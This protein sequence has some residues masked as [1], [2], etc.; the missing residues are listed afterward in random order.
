MRESDKT[1]TQKRKLIDELNS[2]SPAPL[3]ENLQRINSDVKQLQKKLINIYPRFGAPY[4]VALDKFAKAL[5]TTVPE[6]YEKW[7]I[8]YNKGKRENESENLIL[9]KFVREFDNEKFTKAQLAFQKE[10]SKESMEEINEGNL[11]SCL[12]EA[13]G[14][15]RKIDAIS[16]KQYIK[17]MQ[18]TVCSYLEAKDGNKDVA[19]IF[20]NPTVKKLSF[21]K[22]DDAMPRPE[23]VPY[24]F[25]HWRMID[26]LMRRI[27]ASKV[28]YLEEFKRDNLITGDIYKK[29]Y[30]IFTYTMKVKGTMAAIRSF[31]NQMLDAYK[32]YKIYRLK[33]LQLT[34]SD[35]AAKIINES[36]V[37][38]NRSKRARRG[39]GR[40]RR[41]SLSDE[42]LAQDETKA[43]LYVPVLGVDD[44]VEAI[45][46][47][48]YIIY[49]GNEMKR[50]SRK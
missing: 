3:D 29:D 5:G 27:K 44:T 34:S 45:I 4:K 26:D 28:E 42:D 25:K 24:I 36:S 9:Q 22:Y 6:L 16:C 41:G 38:R 33:S 31:M 8:I 39:K 14:L 35:E 20:A 15:P 48:D 49:V 30:L 40:S 18:T 50:G 7:R 46:K 19:V 1:V 21:E 23:E 32:D 12:M 10:I 2:K 47:F 13:M 11:N 43:K 37:S 17:D